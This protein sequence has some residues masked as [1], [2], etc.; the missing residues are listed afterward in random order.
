MT[1]S[2]APVT[3]LVGADPPVPFLK[4]GIAPDDETA[5][6]KALN[7][8]LSNLQIQKCARCPTRTLLKGGVSQP[9]TIY[10]VRRGGG[11]TQAQIDALGK[12]R[13]LVALAKTHDLVFLSHD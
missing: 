4:V 12:A 8:S 9:V 11:F 10:E 7:A 5:L 2:S 3:T 13:A 1:V 6:R